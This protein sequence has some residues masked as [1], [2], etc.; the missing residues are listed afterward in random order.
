MWETGEKD[1][2]TGK[3]TQ[4][5]N[6]CLNRDPVGTGREVGGEDSH[7]GNHTRTLMKH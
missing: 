6:I 2:R 4:R 1:N 5:L 3:S 7:H